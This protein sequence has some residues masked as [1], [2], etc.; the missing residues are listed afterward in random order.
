MAGLT[1]ILAG[2]LV[3]RPA[4]P[5]RQ[6]S[7]KQMLSM[8]YTRSGKRG[9][10]SWRKVAA[11]LG[12]AES[13]LRRWR[14]GEPISMRKLGHLQDVTQTA[15]GGPKRRTVPADSAVVITWTFDGRTRDVAGANLHLAGGTLRSVQDAFMA[16]NDRAA[17]RAF[18][19]GIGDPWYQSR[20]AAHQEAEEKKEHEKDAEEDEEEDEYYEEYY[21]DLYY[22]D[23]VVDEDDYFEGVHAASASG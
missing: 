22:E 17:T 5:R 14:H 9:H 12:V 11:D 15:R 16:G 10:R 3:R 7:V 23:A 1:E 19:E 4:A 20:F 8:A 2:L 18:L 13:T 6:P 21:D